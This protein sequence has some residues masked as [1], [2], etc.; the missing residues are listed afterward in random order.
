[1]R[2]LRRLTAAAH[3]VATRSLPH[4]VDVAQAEGPDA[5]RAAAAPLVAAS[6][7]EVGEL[8]QAFNAVQETAVALA[9]E[10]AA[11]RRNVNDVFVNMGRR[12]QNLITRQ[13]AHI[14]HLENTTE[15]ARALADLFL[16]DHL[17]T[18]LRRNAESLLVLAGAESPRPWSRPVS[19]ASVVRAAVAEATDYSRVD[20]DRLDPASILGVV[21][22]D[23]SHL[24]AELVD[25]A[26][27]FSPPNERVVISGRPVGDGR[28]VVSVADRGIGLSQDRLAELNERIARP[29]V[30]D[31]AMSKYFGLF[32]VGRLA[33]RHGVAVTLSPSPTRGVTAHMTLP[34]SLLV[35]PGALATLGG[36]TAAGPG[37]PPAPLP[38][39]PPAQA[40]VVA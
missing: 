32:V 25:N 5:A 36:T 18:R 33:Q 28:Y 13:L 10:Q 11:L 22:S 31:L 4:A 12:T 38:P 20:V 7:D 27:A 29:P 26:L 39:A 17:A 16:L 14:D 24:L 37:F 1:V 34:T 2:P 23:L 6:G 3:E 9:A 15:D 30:H 40:P 8:T 21:V 35:A 19:V